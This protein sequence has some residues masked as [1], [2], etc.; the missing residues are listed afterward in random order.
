[1]MKRKDKEQGDCEICHKDTTRW[2]QLGRNPKTKHFICKKCRP[3][4]CI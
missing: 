3:I 2:F 4:L 1:M